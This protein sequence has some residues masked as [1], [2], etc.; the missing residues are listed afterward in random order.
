MTNTST[1]ML[2]I[3]SRV[4]LLYSWLCPQLRVKDQ[5]FLKTNIYNQA[6][7]FRETNTNNKDFNFCVIVQLWVS[8]KQQFF[9]TELFIYR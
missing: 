5:C 8:I 6:L 4:R 7:T 3:G 2:S 9:V 1:L